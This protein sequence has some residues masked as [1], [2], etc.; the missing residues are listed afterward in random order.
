MCV[1]MDLCYVML[2]YGVIFACMNI[3]VVSLVELVFLFVLF[4]LFQSSGC[5]LM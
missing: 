2:F 4:V 1:C 3:F 5:A